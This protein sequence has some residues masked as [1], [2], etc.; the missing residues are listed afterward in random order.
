MSEMYELFHYGERLNKEL[1]TRMGHCAYQIAGELPE[2]LSRV[3][4]DEA[5]ENSWF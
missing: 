2:L 4:A 1:P 3:Y 5:G